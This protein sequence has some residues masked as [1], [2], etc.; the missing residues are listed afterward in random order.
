MLLQG[1]RRP[2]A[3]TARESDPAERCYSRPTMS[4]DVELSRFEPLVGER[5][6]LTLPD[7]E[8]VPLELK[9]AGP[10][11][12]LSVKQAAELGKRMPFS[13]VF[14]GPAELLLPQGIRTLSHPEIGELSLFLV[15]LDQ[16]EEASLF[17]AVFT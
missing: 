1:P 14:R 10:V 7:A 13:L 4:E 11:G 3:A 16:T 12:E 6:E 9:E 2:G 17:E 5:F 8:P 15:Q